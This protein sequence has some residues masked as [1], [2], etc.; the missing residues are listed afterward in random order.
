MPIYEYQCGACGRIEEAIQKFSDKPLTTCTHCSGK[1][2]KLISQSAFHLK[3]TGWYVTDYA[4][5]KQNQDSKADSSAAAKKETA[6]GASA[7]NAKTSGNE[8]F[9]R[10]MNYTYT[11]GIDRC[12]QKAELE[13]Q[14][15]PKV[16]CAYFFQIQMHH[17]Q[18]SWE[19]VNQD[20]HC[21]GT[22]SQQN[23]CS[24]QKAASFYK[25]YK[26]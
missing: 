14:T 8:Q 6:N 21:T 23:V 18:L 9:P 19:E 3:G 1:L 12:G 13:A 24:W 4:G 11:L 26:F 7:K 22:T 20:C 16:I 5:K 25:H 17:A 15:V 2:H 10:R